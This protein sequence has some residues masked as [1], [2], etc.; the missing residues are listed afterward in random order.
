MDLYL[1]LAKDIPNPDGS[2][3]F[4]TNPNKTWKDVNPDLPAVKIEVLGPPPTSGTR[5]AF[6]ELAL[7]KGGCKKIK[8]IKALKKKINK[9]INPNVIPQERDGPFIEA[10]ENDNLMVQKLVCQIQT[11]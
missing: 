9:S 8:W 6:S 4:I 3:T 2:E 10:G 7:E 1:A 11:H 5:D